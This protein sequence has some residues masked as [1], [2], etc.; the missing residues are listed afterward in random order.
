MF[1]WP[2]RKRQRNMKYDIIFSAKVTFKNWSNYK[3]LFLS[4]CAGFEGTHCEIEVD[5]CLSSP[6]LNQGKC[7][8]QVSRFVC[9]CPAGWYKLSCSYGFF[10]FILL[11]SSCP[12]SS[13]RFV[14]RFQWWNVPDRHWWVLQ[15]TLFKWGQVHR[16]TQRIWLWMCWR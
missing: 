14:S 4:T 9:E 1:K 8:D 12:F 6:C 15:H 13:C 11:M 2:L 7:L 3:N 16:P 5:E 10:C